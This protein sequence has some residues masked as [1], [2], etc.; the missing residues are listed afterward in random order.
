M[1][2]LTALAPRLLRR[3]RADQVAT[4]FTQWP[5]T[6]AAM[7][8]G[9]AI[10]VT[11]MWGTVPPWMFAAWLAAILANQAW[12]FELVRRYRAAAPAEGQSGR[13]GR[14]W[15]LGSALA[16]ALWGCAGVMLF[17]PGD[18][19]HQALVIVCLFSAIIGGI[20][21]TSVYK[22]A[23]YG[24]VLPVLLPLILRV[25][26]EGDRLHL[27]IA[28]VL[29][30]VLAFILGYGHNLNN[31]MTQSLTIRYENVDLIGELTE[32]TAAA[33]RA[34]ATAET[35]N[36]DK[37][38]FLAAASHDLRQPLHAMGLFGAALAARVHDPAT[39]DIVERI[40]GLVEALERQ[41]T[42]LMDISKLD[43]G[44]V[45]PVRARFPLAPLLAR[46]EREFAPLATARRLR[47][48]ITPTRVWVDSDPALLERIL[49]NFVS[50]AVR[51]TQHGG[52]VVGVR[53]RGA[54][55][56]IEVHD[57]GAGI[58]AA[59]RERIFEAFYQI[60]PTPRGAGQ[61]MGL[62]LAIIRRLSALLEHP[63][64][65]ASTPARGSRFAVVV[66]RAAARALSSPQAHEA[67][68]G[69]SLDGALIAVIDDESAIVDAMRVWFAQ[70]GARVCGGGSGDEALESLGEVGRYPDLIVADYRLAGNAL[71]TDAVAR[72]RAEL[73]QPIPALLIS[74]DA[75]VEAFAVMRA[76][77]LDVLLKPVLPGDLRTLAE[78]LLA[79]SSAPRGGGGTTVCAGLSAAAADRV[80]PKKSAPLGGA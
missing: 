7:V 5:R 68:R 13:W 64:E 21:L 72:L 10:L 28:A 55:V 63:I 57:T 59:E 65:V 73:G 52:A 58:P 14:A 42:A 32:Q 53:R 25:A 50:N 39:R 11:V 31:L 29:L 18:P 17:V 77:A 26:I 54:L 20:N 23:F 4:L 70:W 49:A 62:G 69:G 56:A 45:S 24:F 19:G 76:S 60:S 75:S 12:R 6:T 48:A 2:S 61:G 47:L 80:E 3:A 46:L 43:A 8:L 34:R 35:A 1:A 27:Y 30:V 44:A 67:G 79:A 9:G 15:A 51:H 41:F 38:Q 33:D 78:R 37:T 71:G 74:G 16:G 66:P 22:P 40:N 36:R